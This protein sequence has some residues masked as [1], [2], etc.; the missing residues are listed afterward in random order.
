MKTTVRRRS[1]VTMMIRK[2][3]NNKVDFKIYIIKLDAEENLRR[4]FIDF[5]VKQ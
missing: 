4:F 1:P 2:I 5:F 3:K